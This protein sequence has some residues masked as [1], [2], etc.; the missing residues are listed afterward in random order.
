MKRSTGPRKTA[1][2]SDSIQRHLNMYAVAA[3]AAGIGM[4]ALAQ[5][6][7][8]KIVY[9][10]SN[11]PINVNGGVVDLDLNHDGINDFQFSAFSAGSISVV[12]GLDI[13]PAVKS[14]RVWA[15]QSHG[16]SCAAAVP[17]GNNVGPHR[18]FQLRPYSI[19]LAL[20]EYARSGTYYKFCPWIKGKQAYLGLKFVVK[21]KV[22][23]G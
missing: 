23:F 22:H 21:G 16:I 13:A 12:Q 2:L 7:E 11:I 19:A 6:A 20:G 9:T 10:P 4:I 5:P 18:R 15:V 8:A 3:S 14:N 1:N 17:K